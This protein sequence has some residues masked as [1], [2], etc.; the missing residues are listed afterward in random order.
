MGSELAEKDKTTKYI[1][2]KLTQVSSEKNQLKKQVAGLE[3]VRTKLENEISQLETDYKLARETLKSK[4]VEEEAK[5]NDLQAKLSQVS[6]DL[7]KEEA[8]GKRKEKAKLESEL[9][10][11]NA[12]VKK[13]KA[14][15]GRSGPERKTLKAQLATVK[16]EQIMITKAKEALEAKLATLNSDLNLAKE[17]NASLKAALTKELVKVEELEAKLIRAFPEKGT[18]KKQIKALENER[19]RL[20][21]ELEVLKA[22]YKLAKEE[23]GSLKA[24]MKNLWMSSSEI[25]KE[26]KS[27]RGLEAKLGKLSSELGEVKHRALTAEDQLKKAEADFEGLNKYYQTTKD[28]NFAL[29][30]ELKK[31]QIAYLKEVNTAAKLERKSEQLIQD[32]ARENQRGKDVEREW[33][34][35]KSEVADLKRTKFLVEQKGEKIAQASQEELLTRVSKFSPEELT[36]D[37]VKIYQALGYVYLLDGD[38]K[39]AINVYKKALRLDPKDKDVHYNLG[40][41]YTKIGKYKHAVNAYEEALSGDKSDDD[42]YYNLGLIYSKYLN[43]PRKAKEYFGMMSDKSEQEDGDI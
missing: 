15:L 28:E 29:K 7:L 30:Q 24:S 42:I 5:V 43:N 38:F 37:K 25:A 35:I 36:E 41:S 17:L 10:E 12:T 40:Y 32:L 39:E 22:E 34:A 8:K 33:Q 27:T 21:D 1:Q 6:S 14:K 13:L 11:K 19:G 31:A 9:A 3:A 23:V 20:K 16:K 26:E 18:F 4:L 2:D